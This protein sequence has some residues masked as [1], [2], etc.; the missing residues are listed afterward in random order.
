MLPGSSALQAAT[1]PARIGRSAAVGAAYGGAS[2]A[3]EGT[4][5][6]DRASRGAIGTGLG[7]VVGG[8]AAPVVGKAVEL[9]GRG[10][11]RIGS[12]I[13]QA[14]RGLSDE[15]VERQAAYNVLS[16][17][18]RDEASRGGVG[19]NKAEYDA[20]QAAGVPVAL[21]DRGGAGTQSLAR[22]AADTSS[23]AESALKALSGDRYATQSPR[24][25]SWLKDKFDFPDVAA[26][27]D[28]I[29]DAARR[30][31]APAYTRAYTQPSAQAIWDDGL[32]QFAQAP[33][34]QNAIRLAFVTARNRGAMDGF[35]P[36]K[37]PF[38]MNSDGVFVLKTGPNGERALPN[39]QFWDHVKR[40][41]DTMGG[42]GQ[43]F[44]RALRNHLDEIV[45]SYKDARAGAAKFFGA[46]DALEA[47]GKFAMMGGS[48]ALKLG[49][50]YQVLSKMSEPDKKLFQTGF[51]ANLIA[52]VENLKDGQ[53]VVKNIFNTE[54]ARK[55]I[56]MV[57]GTDGANQLEAK[58]LSERAM[59]QLRVALGNSQ[60][61]KFLANL[62]KAGA[63]NPYTLAGGAAAVTTYGSGSVGP[64]DAFAAALVFA[65]RKGQIK[66]DERVARRV[67]E[68]LASS[69]EAVLKRGVDLIARNQGMR[70]ALRNF[71]LTASRAGSS[72][73]PSTIYG[74]AVPSITRAE[75][76]PEVP[77][78][79]R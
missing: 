71:D 58:L 78:P 37:N 50:A 18:A 25:A 19:F 48:D 16:T 62:A 67:G 51:V 66:I 44:S 7:A 73:A 1:L 64:G 4:T 45:P 22:S 32:G 60:T 30:A 3:G 39:L 72:Q 20:A 74:S 49:Q 9:A 31:N 10:I 5:V 59:D 47:G 75:D 29:K 52:K 77:G 40:N 54:S 12:P 26:K 15:G 69:D 28:Q 14:V 55:Q 63:T 33:V 34:V 41:L 53:D 21:A 56:S 79:P 38:V 70:T 35:P 76:Q 36:I 65:A 8:V 42:D 43:A 13:A 6:E 24:I 17:R 61:S 27:L 57:L 2:G 46:E 23:E 68:M 11:A